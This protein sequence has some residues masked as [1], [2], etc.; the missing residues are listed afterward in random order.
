V[1]RKKL[2]IQAGL[3]I[4]LVLAGAGVYAALNATSLKARF[5]A[6]QLRNASTDDARA[7]AADKLAALGDRGLVKLVAFVRDGEEPCR[8]AAVCAIQ[9][10]L[11]SPPKS[12]AWTTTLSERLIAASTGAPA[13]GQRAIL[14]LTA[15]MVKHGGPNLMSRWR[16][17]VAA[18]LASADPETRALSV[19]LALHASLKLHAAVVPLLA[20][21][22]ATVRRAALV[23]V[24]TGGEPLVADED[25]FRWLHDPDA[26]VRAICHDVLVSHER[27]ETEI[28]LGR[29]LANPDSRERRKLLHDLRDNESLADPE[30]WLERLSR[31]TEPA[32]RAGAA[33]VAAEIAID[34]RRSCP[35]WIDRIADADP[36]QTVRRV[37]VFFRGMPAR[38]AAGEIRPAGGP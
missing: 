33:R 26:G 6:H 37:A 5:T 25:L 28:S 21:P 9:R 7:R 8:R 4:L 31:D 36:D 1:K 2:V 12:D 34:R 11:E 27:T 24:A 38:A 18:G 13:G 20:D 3:G 22:E 15:V 16:E 10:R 14:E 19:R 32:I 23:A 30:P 35:S 17:L 29:R